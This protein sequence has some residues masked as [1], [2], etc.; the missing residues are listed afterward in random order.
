MAKGGGV[1]WIADIS[2]KLSAVG[3]RGPYGK[4]TA[5]EASKGKVDC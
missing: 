1:Q 3:S 4:Y 5:G 2:I